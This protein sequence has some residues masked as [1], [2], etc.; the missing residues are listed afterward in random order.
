MSG[1]LRRRPWVLMRILLATLCVLSASPLLVA[2]ADGRLARRFEKAVTVAAPGSRVVP[3][4]TAPDESERRWQLA[5]GERLEVRSWIQES[6][7]A[8]EKF[9]RE[10]AFA[11]PVPNTRIYGFGDEAYLL[12]PVSRRFERLLMFRHGRVVVETRIRGEENVRHFA[13]LFAKEVARAIAV[14]EVER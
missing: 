7:A 9:A 3:R 11:I 10:L 2:Q 12:A 5:D 13:A 4:R 14:G 8:A 1:T 6:P